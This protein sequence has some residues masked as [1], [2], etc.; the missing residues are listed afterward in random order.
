VLI[1]ALCIGIRF[2]LFRSA[3]Q[4][5]RYIMGIWV[6]AIDSIVST[7]VA[8]GV[9]AGTARTVTTRHDTTVLNNILM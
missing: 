1:I 9:S 2:V 6:L 5:T 3:N 7:A 4:S 8:V